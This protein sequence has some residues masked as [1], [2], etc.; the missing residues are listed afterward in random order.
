VAVFTSE[1]QVVGLLEERYRRM[2]VT[3]RRERSRQ[4]ACNIFRLTPLTRHGEALDR[5]M[6]PRLFRRPAGT[7]R[8]AGVAVV[9]ERLRLVGGISLLGQPLQDIVIL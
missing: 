1:H 2:L 8:T 9:L 7:D 5:P 4:R 3:C 6:R